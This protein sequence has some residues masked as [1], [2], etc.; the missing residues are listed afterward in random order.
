MMKL[1]EVL[2]SSQLK[3]EAINLLILSRK[4]GENIIIKL[5][6]KKVEIHILEEAGGEIKLG[7]EASKD[8]KIYRGEIY[9]KIVDQNKSSVNSNLDIVNFLK[10]ELS[11]GTE[12]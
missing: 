5:G 11:R 1:K 7:L 4:K 9:K 6:D 12:N 2:L 10:E 8:I 3:K